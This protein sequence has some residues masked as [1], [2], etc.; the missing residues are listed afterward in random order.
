[1]MI[2]RRLNVKMGDV[3]LKGRLRLEGQDVD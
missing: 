3:E 1:M 2:E